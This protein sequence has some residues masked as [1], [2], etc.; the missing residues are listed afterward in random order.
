VRQRLCVQRRPDLY[1]VRCRGSD[2]L[3][4]E[5]VQ[6]RRMLD[7][8]SV[9]AR[10]ADVRHARRRRGMHGRELRH[11]RGRGRAVLWDYLHGARDDLPDRYVR[12]VRYLRQSAV[13]RRLD[14]RGSARVYRRH[15]Q[16]KGTSRSS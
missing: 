4:P 5:Y 11:L 9:R 8:C 7:R 6:R 2:P 16:V 12:P 14:L 3:C 13:L 10:G 15:L 1:E